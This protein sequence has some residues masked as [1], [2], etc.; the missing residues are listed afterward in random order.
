MS[1]HYQTDTSMHTTAQG[2]SKSTKYQEH[3][4]GSHH[5]RDLNQTTQTNKPPSLIIYIIPLAQRFT[6]IT[7]VA[8]VISPSVNTFFIFHIFRIENKKNLTLWTHW[9]LNWLFLPNPIF[10]ICLNFQQQNPLKNQYLAHLSSENCEINSIKS[11]SPRGPSN[12]TKNTPK[13]QYSFFVLDFI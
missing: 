5:L 11:D 10:A 7:S 13:F 1:K 4:R 2:I 3:D 12:N 9:G 6:I 8:G